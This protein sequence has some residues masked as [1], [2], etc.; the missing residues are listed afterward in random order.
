MIRM[1]VSRCEIF[2]EFTAEEQQKYFSYNGNKVIHNIDTF[3][4]SVYLD[5]FDNEG[6]YIE[7]MIKF[8]D[9]LSDKYKQGEREIMV[10]EL[11]FMPL[12]FSFYEYCLRLENMYDIFISRYLPNKNTP[13]VVIQLRSIGLWMDGTKPLIESSYKD[14][15]TFMKRFYVTVTKVTENRIDYAY[16][17]N[18]IQNTTKYFSDKNML[19][20]LKTQ[21]E[22]YQKVGN[23]GKEITVDYLSLGMRKSNNL[24]FRAYNK[25]REVIEQNYKGFFIEYWH[26]HK[27]ISDYDKWILE[28]AYQL[29]T[30]NSL[31]VARIDWYL[32]H[33]KNEERKK[34]LRKLK[35]S[36][37]EKSDNSGYIA[38]ELNGV[39]PDVNVVVNVEFQTKR[40]FYYTMNKFIDE[41]PSLIPPNELFYRIYQIIDN[42]K[43]FLD[44]LTSGTV[45]FMNGD[46]YASWWQRIRCVKVESIE[47]GGLYREYARK[48][49]IEKLKQR[50]AGTIASSSVYRNKC[51]DNG[52][53]DDVSDM[54][55]MLNDNDVAGMVISPDTGEL[56][57]FSYRNYET[58]KKRK[59]RQLKAFFKDEI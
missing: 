9:E 10:G 47:N 52:F 36:C 22:R 27:L 44:Y 56:L 46:D 18:I 50:M 7:N 43:A 49:D 53:S 12:K 40:K 20:S 38:D 41:L 14:M 26:K 15:E 35:R 5:E 31:L 54:L 59:N 6:K 2:S 57:E 13:R 8:L 39:L 1:E 28:K 24:F 30:Y 21:L 4:Y 37:Y 11:S 16:H 48:L 34:K 3:Y 42:R 51:N 55:C 17:T 33:G 45:A 19:E 23:I 58:L 25:T 32:Q 29:G